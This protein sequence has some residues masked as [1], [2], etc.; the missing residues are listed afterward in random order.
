[1]EED[2]Q[3]RERLRLSG[4]VPKYISPSTSGETS[5]DL[6][7]TPSESILEALHAKLREGAQMSMDGKEENGEVEEGK[8]L[9]RIKE[10]G[11]DTGGS[12]RH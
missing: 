4:G 11:E 10:V 5:P 12:S 9:M 6:G 2:I 3:E 1:M 8:G 7:S